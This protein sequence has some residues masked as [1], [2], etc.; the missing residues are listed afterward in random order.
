MG[1]LSE[2]KPAA[3]FTIELV[4]HAAVPSFHKEEIDD[5]AII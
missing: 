5:K 1:I 3:D 4:S 2:P